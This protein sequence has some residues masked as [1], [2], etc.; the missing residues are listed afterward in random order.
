VYAPLALVVAVV[1]PPLYDTVAPEMAVP[2][3]LVTV[4]EM[5]PLPDT[6]LKLVVVVV[7]AVTTTPVF[8]ADWNPVAVAVTL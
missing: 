6:R 2:V 7:L 4:P 1:A 8:V 5:V 3:E